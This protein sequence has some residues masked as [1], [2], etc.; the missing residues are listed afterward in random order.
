VCAG[1]TSLIG[2][3]GQQLGSSSLFD[4][5]SAAPTIEGQVLANGTPFTRKRAKSIP[6]PLFYRSID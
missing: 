5:L 4:R 6:L 2:I 1:K 3:L